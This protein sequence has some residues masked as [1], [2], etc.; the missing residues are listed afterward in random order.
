MGVCRGY[1]HI[2]Y[3]L[4]SKVDFNMQA[5]LREDDVLTPTSLSE[6]E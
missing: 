5:C 4:K 2:T 3:N 1:N 6:K